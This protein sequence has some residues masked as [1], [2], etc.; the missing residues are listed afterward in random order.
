MP[1]STRSV[2]DSQRALTRSLFGTTP[3][4]ASVEA[5]TIRNRNGVEVRVITYGGIIQSLRTP[6][7]NGAFADIVLG[8]DGLAGYL[9]ASPYFGALVGRYGNRIAHGRFTV[10][11]TAYVLKANDGPHHL[12]G[13]VTGF[14]KVVWSAEPFQDN[15]TSGLVLRHTSPHGDEGYPGTL[16]AQVTYALSDANELVIDYRATTDRATPVNLLQHSYFN[17]GGGSRDI[18][19]HILSIDADR[20]TPIDDTLIPTGEFAPVTGTPFDFRTPVKIGSRIAAD[21]QQLKYGNGYDHNFVLN[22]RGALAPA[23]RLSDPSTGRRLDVTTSEPGLQVYTGNYL[24]GTIQGKSGQ[25]YYRRWGLTLETQHFPDSPN[26][27][28]FP[29]TILYPGA[30]YRSRTV[31]TFGVMG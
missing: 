22:H 20:F 17:L 21:H 31:F 25:T 9:E 16:M 8:H 12:H 6:D 14:D 7:R 4:G 27:P 19:D 28:E 15:T 18:L 13:G 5:F 10:N 26:H 30:D 29:S 11:E 24:Y 3:E 23:A 2:I 1:E